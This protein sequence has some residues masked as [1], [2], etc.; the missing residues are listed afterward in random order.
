MT[1]RIL[2][3]AIAVTC[4]GGCESLM[5]LMQKPPPKPRPS[6]HPK[7]KTVPLRRTD[8]ADQLVIIVGANPRDVDADGYPDLLDVTA[9]LFEG[10]AGEPVFVDGRFEFELEP[11]DDSVTR[12]WRVW[13]ISESESTSAAGPTLFDLP[14]YGF[15]L[16]L[17]ENGGDQM[18]PIAANLVGRFSP[19]SGAATVDCVPGQRIVQLGGSERR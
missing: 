14:G 11:L 1:I 10:Q 3:A 4:I 13:Q 18:P 6:F 19:A 7:P 8:R 17:R 15:T 2:V 9:I 5:G 16:D 12:P